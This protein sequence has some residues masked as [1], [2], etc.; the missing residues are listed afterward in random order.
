MNPRL[1]ALISGGIWKTRPIDE[2]PEMQLARWS[3]WEVGA[4]SSATRH[5]V[6]YNLIDH[7]G[8]VYARRMEARTILPWR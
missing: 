5:L 7:E 4:G 2:Q 1:V 8:R 6:G 3:I